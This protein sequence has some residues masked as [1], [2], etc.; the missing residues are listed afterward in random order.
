MENILE[1]I[2]LIYF[3][4]INIL[5]LLIYGYDK[6]VAGTGRS[7]VRER[8]LLILATLGG[9]IG[10]I[11]A[12]KLFHHKTRKSSF[13]VWFILILILQVALVVFLFRSKLHLTN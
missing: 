12:M 7:R 2:V 11:I 6:A 4:L 5:T 3:C 10:A 13:L 8:T 1:K 9:S